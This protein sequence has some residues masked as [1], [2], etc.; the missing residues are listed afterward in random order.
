L[1]A[2]FHNNNNNKP[3]N[4]ISENH[5]SKPEDKVSENNDDDDWQAGRD[6]EGDF[7]RLEWAIQCSNAE[8]HLQQE[9]RLET[10]DYLAQ[11]RRS[12]AGDL[13]RQVLP[14]VAFSGALASTL[15]LQPSTSWSR[16]RWMI[17]GW[18]HSVEA[19]SMLHFWC[20]SVLAP[21]VLLLY[22]KWWREASVKATR[23]DEEPTLPY[24]LR[25]LGPEYLRY[26]TDYE[27]PEEAS[28]R[29]HVRCLLEQWISAVA[30]IAVV[31]PLWWFC[32]AS[33]RRSQPA[34]QMRITMQLIVRLAAAASWH[35]YPQLWFQ[36]V[37]ARQPRP[38][39]APVAF[40]QSLMGVQLTRWTVAT[41]L[42]CL[43]ATVAPS[44]WHLGLGYG[45][46]MAT[47]GLVA[48]AARWVKPV[49]ARYNESDD[50][51]NKK[52]QWKRSL[53][54][55]WR[56][57]VKFLASAATILWILGRRS[58]Y[59][60]SALGQAATTAKTLSVE[61]LLLYFPWRKILNGLG[62]AVALLGPVCSHLHAFRKLVRVLYT[63]NLSLALGAEGFQEALREAESDDTVSSDKKESK[64]LIQWRYKLTWREPERIR[65]TLD[66]WRGAFWYWLFLKG[67]V[68]E[69]LSKEAGG[70]FKRE[71]QSRGLTIWERLAKEKAQYP[72]APFPDRTEWKENAM[73]RVAEWHQQ[74]YDANTIRV[75]RKHCVCSKNQ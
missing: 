38:L 13:F 33:G 74:D 68:Q 53:L 8:E 5:E 43:A 62:V 40:M 20:C 67:S 29:D 3:E 2:N 58:Q 46:G 41:D 70:R 4:E 66:R 19:V 35:Q 31:G 36:L 55:Q 39:P 32:S 9:E 63:H 72:D 28:C 44:R 27:G 73:K 51:N 6:V 7:Q 15:L 24:A 42:A 61:E 14:L 1:Y 16:R 17:G 37:R 49:S 30:G 18:K 12:L 34:T 59:W 57:A 52:N 50:D 26:L 45:L 64:R 10:L 11:Q 56:P 21:M 22:V 48:L 60:V 47:V 65:V 69:K 71:F 25:D 23:M 54:A 75:R